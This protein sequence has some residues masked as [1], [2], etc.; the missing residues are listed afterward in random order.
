MNFPLGATHDPRQLPDLRKGLIDL[1]G[2]GGAWEQSEAQE[3]E[4]PV[5]ST[6]S[7]EEKPGAESE[8]ESEQKEPQKSPKGKETEKPAGRPGR[9]KGAP[10][11][12]RTQQLPIDAEQPH[13][14][15]SCAICGGPLDESHQS[16]PHNAHYVLDLVPPAAGGSGLVVRQTKQQFPPKHYSQLEQPLRSLWKKVLRKL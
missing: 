4:A 8:S 5:A 2:D 13:A 6:Q 7:A 15:H 16:R 9:R 11:H 12:S 1:A 3:P 14:P 10:G